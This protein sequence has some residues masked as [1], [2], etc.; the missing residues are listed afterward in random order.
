MKCF[1]TLRTILS[2]FQGCLHDSSGTMGLNQLIYSISQAE[3]RLQFYFI[4]RSWDDLEFVYIYN[5]AIEEGW[6]SGSH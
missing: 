5:S 2:T 6:R 3:F 1:W 4:L